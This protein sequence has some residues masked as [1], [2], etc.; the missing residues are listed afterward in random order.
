MPDTITVIYDMVHRNG[1][2]RARRM[3]A[4]YLNDNAVAD[5]EGK[6]HADIE[7]ITHEHPDAVVRYGTV[8]RGMLWV[9]L[10]E[11]RADGIEY[12]EAVA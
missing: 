6:G 7:R 1:Y 12:H 5:G 4:I 11:Y 10:S 9:R 8:K 3:Y 2:K